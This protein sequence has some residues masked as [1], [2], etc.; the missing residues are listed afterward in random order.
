MKDSKLLLKALYKYLKYV[1]VLTLIANEEQWKMAQNYVSN[2]TDIKFY[3]IR[4]RM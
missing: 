1:N 2:I 4:N 3:L